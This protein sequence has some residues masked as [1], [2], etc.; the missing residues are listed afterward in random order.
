TTMDRAR[1][2]LGALV[3]EA[4]EEFLVPAAARDLTVEVQG[5]G[6]PLEV[7]AD[8]A[9]LRQALAHLLDH[10]VPVAPAGS[11]VSV[12]CGADGG[13]AWAAVADEGPGIPADQQGLV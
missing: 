6:A 12:S 8:R 5:P 2:D 1:V 7:D 9:A 13:G 10:A 4:A 3:A 11:R